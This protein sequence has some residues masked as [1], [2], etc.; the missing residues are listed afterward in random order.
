MVAGL[1]EVCERLRSCGEALCPQEERGCGRTCDLRR[2][3]DPLRGVAAVFRLKS[4]F[5][6]CPVCLEPMVAG[7]AVAAYA[8]THK[9][10]AECAE[11]WQRRSRDSACPI[12]DTGRECPTDAPVV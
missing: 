1:G 5:D 3:E 2:C 6:D 11:R 10:H 12:C 4:D 9:I 8:C 7:E